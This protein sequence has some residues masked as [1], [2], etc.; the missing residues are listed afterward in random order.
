MSDYHDLGYIKNI[1]FSPEET[2]VNPKE[3][4]YK[5]YVKPFQKVCLELHNGLIFYLKCI[6]TDRVR[7]LRLKVVHVKFRLVVMA[8]CDLSSI[9]GHR[10]EQ[11]TLFRILALFWCP[12]VNNDVDKFIRSCTYFQF[13]NSLSN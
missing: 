2:P 5:G 6:Y 9:S 8:A 4:R 11:R 7:K 12:M 10:H 1:L 13:V 3:L